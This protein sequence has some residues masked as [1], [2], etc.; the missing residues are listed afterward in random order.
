MK[1]NIESTA[2]V[3]G[4]ID[5]VKIVTPDDFPMPPGGLNIRPQDGVLDQEARLQDFKRDAMLAFVR[6]T[7]STASSSP[8]AASPRWA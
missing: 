3:D 1:E 7:T 8:A 5:R 6:P 2:S 4:S